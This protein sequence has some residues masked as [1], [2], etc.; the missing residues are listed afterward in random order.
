MKLRPASCGSLAK[1]LPETLP[2]PAEEA[3]APEEDSVTAGSGRCLEAE[4]WSGE[5]EVEDSNSGLVR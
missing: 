4:G 5:R 2:G 1:R 3:P